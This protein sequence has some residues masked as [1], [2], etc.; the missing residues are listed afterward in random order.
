MSS[1]SGQPR[2]ANEPR[3]RSGANTSGYLL[4]APPGNRGD[5]LGTMN[6]LILESDEV[7]DDGRVRIEGRRAKHLRHVLK[8]TPGQRL[9]GG[10]L[11][12]PRVTVT[13]ESLEDRGEI[14][15]RVDGEDSTAPEST[16]GPRIELIVALP[17]PQ[18]LHRVLQFAAAMNI[19]HLDLIASWRVEKSFFQ[20]PSLDPQKIRRQLRLGAEQGMTT[21][22]PRVVLHH[23]FVPFLT[24]LQTRPAALR[25]LGE[26]DGLPIETVFRHAPDTPTL[27]LAIGPEGG[28]V[29]REIATFRESGFHP[30]GFGPW[31]LRV[32]AAVVA[33]L[34][35]IELLSRI[36]QE[37]TSRC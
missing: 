13:V 30:V 6:L 31:I 18:V 28:F 36:H 35:Q 20:S 23:R 26:P 1:R 17:R 15:L 37:S 3:F 32:E 2:E 27:Q 4:S 21:R 9:R 11:D 34:A 24:Q 10:L 12:G 25:L 29:E 14:C 8:V 16:N 19:A 5:I 33:V 7:D 22:I